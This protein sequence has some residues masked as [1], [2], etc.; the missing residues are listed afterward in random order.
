MN[1]YGR[2]DIEVFKIGT[3]KKTNILIKQILGDE[4]ILVLVM[5]LNDFMQ[6][7]ESLKK[8]QYSDVCRCKDLPA[9]TTTSNGKRSHRT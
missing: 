3:L 1:T 9:F 8:P 4:M 5:S 6:T 7:M 2:F